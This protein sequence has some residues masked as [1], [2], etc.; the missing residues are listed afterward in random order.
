[1]ALA[2]DMNWSCLYRVFDYLETIG[3]VKRGYFVHG[4]GGIQFARS[5]AVSML[6]QTAQHANE[7][8]VLAKEDPAYPGQFSG[9]QV[10]GGSFT[11]FRAGIPVLAI[12]KRL[13]FEEGYNEA[14]LWPS[15]REY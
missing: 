4:L 10:K 7:W 5:D 3:E 13:G 1:M 9:E 6:N 11:V 12:L 2:E 8:W 14:V 15:Q